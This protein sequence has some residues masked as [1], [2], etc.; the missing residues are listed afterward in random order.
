MNSSLFTAKNIIVQG[1]T[2]AHGKFQT[3]AM[4]AAGT[5]IVAG[6]TPGKAGQ[7]VEGV[8]VYNTI[9]DV[10]KDFTI[11]SSV[12][13]V[14]A[15]FVKSAIFEAISTNIPLIV[16]ITEGVPIHDMI[17]IKKRLAGSNSI[18]VGP[19]GRAHV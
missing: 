3:K 12:I 7:S 13:F 16:C 14:P 18:L 10:Q 1:I 15:P 4:L 19:I 9:A 8:P 2:G 6:V 11:D 17:Q 5:N